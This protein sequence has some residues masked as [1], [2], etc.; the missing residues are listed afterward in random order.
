MYPY[1]ATRSPSLGSRLPPGPP[2]LRS[3]LPPPPPSSAPPFM[4]NPQSLNPNHSLIMDASNALPSFSPLDSYQ[5]RSHFPQTS[6]P[7]PPSEPAAHPMPR[8]SPP[9]PLNY[10]L[11]RSHAAASNVPSPAVPTHNVYTPVPSA[12]PVSLPTTYASAPA[13]SAALHTAFGSAPSAYA[14]AP[15]SCAP[16]PAT[17]GTAPP[18]PPPPLRPPSMSL[19]TTYASSSCALPMSLPNTYGGVTTPPSTTL[20]SQEQPILYDMCKLLNTGCTVFRGRV[21]NEKGHV[22]CGMLNQHD[23]PC[24]RIGKCPFH[25][26]HVP[27]TPHNALN[28]HM[29]SAV[30]HLSPPS[31]SA[32]TASPFSAT[33]TSANAAQGSASPNGPP[34]KRQ[35]K[36]GWT[37]EEHYLFLLGLQRHGRGNWKIIAETIPSRTATQVQSHAQKYFQRLKQKNKR[38][39]SIHDSHLGSE[40]LEQVR[41]MY[42]IQPAQ[43]VQQYVMSADNTNVQDR[44]RQLEAPVNNTA[45]VDVLQTADNR[46]AWWGSSNN[47]SMH[48][49]VDMWRMGG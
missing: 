21:Y 26:Q 49:G 41:V 1:S 34:P 27:V 39:R 31:R 2:L 32:S 10:P 46:R 5:S 17:Y 28:M 43:T 7:L 37:K 8:M 24:K 19:A 35:F 29:L 33:P 13:P 23:Q 40:D 42:E 44:S 36:R 14:A 4:P 3:P 9:I 6:V 47:A 18:P 20:H 30:T 22:I 25:T 16:L 15:T 45:M 12:P 48:A 38:K 11:L